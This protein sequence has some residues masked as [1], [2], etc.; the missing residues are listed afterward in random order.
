MPGPVSEELYLTVTLTFSVQ[1]GLQVPLPHG[2]LRILAGTLTLMTG[3]GAS[4]LPQQSP[5][6]I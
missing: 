6:L 3:Y 5:G 1:F 4:L 2:D